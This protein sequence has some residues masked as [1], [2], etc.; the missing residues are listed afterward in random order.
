[1]NGVQYIV[2]DA[3]GHGYLGGAQAAADRLWAF[4]LKGPADGV[5][6]PRPAGP[7]LTDNVT[8]LSG[9]PMR[10][11]KVAV[12]D[13]GY[14]PSGKP[15]GF[16]S[17]IITVPAGATITWINTGSQPHTSTSKDGH[18]DTGVIPPGGSA[19]T[20]MKQAGTFHFYCIPHPWMT[21]EVIVTPI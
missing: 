19:T 14:K 2:L 3:G 10:T 6:I 1:V 11:S 21:G 9:A 17:L 16:G 13:Y 7:A 18:W 5:A 15:S 12:F 4:S 20:V 8:H